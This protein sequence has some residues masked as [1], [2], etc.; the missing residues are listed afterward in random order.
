VIVIV[1]VVVVVRVRVR[2]RGSLQARHIFVSIATMRARS[3]LPSF[4]LSPAI[5]PVTR[6]TSSSAA[7]S[8]AEPRAIAW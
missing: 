4:A 2:V 5:T 6:Q 3:A 1:V 8:I 7:H